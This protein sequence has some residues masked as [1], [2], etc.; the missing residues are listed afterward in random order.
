MLRWDDPEAADT[1]PAG[2]L[3]CVAVGASERL[4]AHSARSALHPHV[5]PGGGWGSMLPARLRG[6]ESK[7]GV[8]WY[9][10]LACTYLGCVRM[11]LA[12]GKVL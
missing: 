7:E 11:L 9:V 2:S 4:A 12:L 3:T 1:W 8:P 6:Q 10:F 5:V